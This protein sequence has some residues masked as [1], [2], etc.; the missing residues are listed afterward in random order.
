MAKVERKHSFDKRNYYFEDSPLDDRVDALEQKFTRLTVWT[1]LITFLLVAVIIAAV[2][3]QIVLNGK[4]PTEDNSTEAALVRHSQRSLDGTAAASRN[5][6]TEGDTCCKD[7]EEQMTQKLRTILAKLDQISFLP[8]ELEPHRAPHSDVVPKP[9]GEAPAMQPPVISLETFVEK[10]NEYDYPYDQI[11]TGSG[12]DS[13]YLDPTFYDY[14]L[15]DSEEVAGSGFG[16]NLSDDEDLA[17]AGSGCRVFARP[18]CSDGC[19]TLIMQAGCPV[20]ICCRAVPEPDHN[21]QSSGHN[22]HHH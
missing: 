20:P 15:R 1:S 4:A 8:N 17:V 22:H 12:D 16:T 9:A 13:F 21:S 14:D 19:I 2:I 10:G 3:V 18:V 6:G 11:E 5:R 7:L